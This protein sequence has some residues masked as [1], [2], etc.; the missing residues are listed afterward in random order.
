MPFEGGEK[1]AI[2][3]NCDVNITRQ[4]RTK[5]RAAAEGKASRDTEAGALEQVSQQKNNVQDCQKVVYLEVNFW[6]KF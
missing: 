5:G 6:Y 2:L 3:A 1:L 4:D